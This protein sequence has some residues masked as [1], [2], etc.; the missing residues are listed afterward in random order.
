M[1]DI[2]IDEC[3]GPELWR[4]SPNFSDPQAEVSFGAVS[5][6]SIIKTT[7]MHSSKDYPSQEAVLK[8]ILSRSWEESQKV[9]KRRICQRHTKCTDVTRTYRSQH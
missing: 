2:G 8:L 6:T 9:S 7:V 4:I 1:P 3:A 5:D